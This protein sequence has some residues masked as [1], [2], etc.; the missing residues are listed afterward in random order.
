M[1]RRKDKAARILARLQEM[2]PHPATEL[3][4]ATPWQLLAAAVL[5]AQSTDRQ[6]NKVTA[7]L[8]SKYPGPEQMAL[9]EPEELAGEI[10][11]L[12]LFRNKSRHLVAAAR[13]VVEQ[14]GGRVPDSLEKLQKL[15][16][17][18]RK[19]ANVV[20]SVAYGIPALA[21]DTH[22]FRVANRTGLARARTPEETEKQLT[23]AIPRR[24]WSDAH[25]W[26]ILHGRYICTARK[27]H[28]DRCPVWEDCDDYRSK[29]KKEATE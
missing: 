29:Q 25:H 21:V 9:L 1:A 5:S 3:N 27:P 14:Y 4:F 17:V 15:P 6:V 23:R 20:L 11:T 19:T 12:G 24:Q 18:G 8:F 10:Q 26:L 2:H 22:V 16:G 28:C 7:G 13:A